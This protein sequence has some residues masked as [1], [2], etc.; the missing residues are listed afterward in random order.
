MCEFQAGWMKIFTGLRRQ[1]ITHL[2][3]VLWMLSFTAI[4]KFLGR[5]IGRQ[6]KAIDSIF[7][8][9]CIC[10]R[11]IHCWPCHHDVVH[12]FCGINWFLFIHWEAFFHPKVNL[13]E[14]NRFSRQQPIFTEMAEIHE[15]DRFSRNTPISTKHANFHET[16]Q[17]PR[18]RPIFTKQANFQETRHFPRKCQFPRKKKPNFH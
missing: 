16:R 1:S 10:A 6:Y 5:P 15:N 11:V 18:N 4:D 3:N 9:R 13:H 17:F 12:I 7:N 14:N 8:D 2:M